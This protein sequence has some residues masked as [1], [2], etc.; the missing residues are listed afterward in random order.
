MNQSVNLPHAFGNAGTIL[1]ILAANRLAYLSA[2]ANFLHR[3]HFTLKII[4]LTT[5]RFVFFS[6][7]VC[8]INLI[9]NSYKWRKPYLNPPQL[10]RQVETESA[11]LTGC[12]KQ[13]YVLMKH[14]L[15]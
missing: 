9:G 14:P 3:R 4:I 1:S 6:L 12:K 13:V 5:Q 15:S 11:E 7:Q 2:D 10:L 8:L